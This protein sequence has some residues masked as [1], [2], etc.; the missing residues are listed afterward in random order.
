MFLLK[1]QIFLSFFLL[2]KQELFWDFLSPNEFSANTNVIDLDKFNTFDNSQSNNQ[3]F[4][5]KFLSVGHVFMDYNPKP[6]CT[7]DYSPTESSN[8][9][10]HLHGLVKKSKFLW[11]FDKKDKL[12]FISFDGCYTN[13]NTTGTLLVTNN[14]NIDFNKMLNK[15]HFWREFNAHIECEKLCK[16]IYERCYIEQTEDDEK[17]I[18]KAYKMAGY[19]YDWMN[20]EEIQQVQEEVSWLNGHQQHLIPIVFGVISSIILI[21]FA[22][23][24]Y[25]KNKV[26]VVIPN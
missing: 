22:I 16:I 11:N 21:S 7:V 10:C 25:F 3:Y 23:Y 26:C 1:F 8:S 19:D 5:M 6:T 2:T 12:I 20:P 13:N 15:T 17:N 9:S 4:C 24:K 18:I 14:K